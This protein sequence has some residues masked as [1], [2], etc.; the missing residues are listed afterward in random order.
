MLR[1]ELERLRRAGRRDWRRFGLLVGGV[2]IA[3]GVAWFFRH[4]PF[5]WYVLVPG[6]P[7]VV[8]GAAAPRA[9]KWPYVAW[10]T[11]AMALGAVIST[12]LLCLLFYFV[13][14]P[15][16]LLARLAGKDFLARK[17]DGA[18]RSYWIA[19]DPAKPKGKRA[20]EMQ[21]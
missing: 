10:M 14:T 3:L 15:V 7:L 19:R 1:D 6:V 2:F 5:Y 20:H 16:G 12:V 8:L 4:K 17:L 18:A 13:V 9:L 11:M 21:F